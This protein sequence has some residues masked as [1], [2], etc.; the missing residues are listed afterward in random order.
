M[1]KAESS[2]TIHQ[3][4]AVN[5]VLCWELMYNN[6]NNNNNNDNNDDDDNVDDRKLK[7]VPYDITVH[8]N[9]TL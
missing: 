7:K 1:K 2:Y 6:N 9:Y 3:C 8:V 5:I 4:F